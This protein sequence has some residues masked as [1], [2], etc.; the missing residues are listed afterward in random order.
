M[1]SLAIKRRKAMHY[2]DLYGLTRQDRLELAEMLLRKDVETWSTLDETELFRLL[3]ALE[4]YGL[5]THLMQD[6]QP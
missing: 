2:C 5:I 3:D 1:D 6:R 4:G